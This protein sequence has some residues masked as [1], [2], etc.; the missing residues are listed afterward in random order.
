MQATLSRRENYDNIKHMAEEL[1]VL[2]IISGFFS[3]QVHH[4]SG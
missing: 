2:P 4:A 3:R 1:H